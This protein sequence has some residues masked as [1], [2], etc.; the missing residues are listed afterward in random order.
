MVESATIRS[1]DNSRWPGQLS[2][3]WTSPPNDPLWTDQLSAWSS[4]ATGIFS[5]IVALIALFAWRTARATLHATRDAAVAARESNEQAKIDSIEQT[6]PYVYA[7]VVPGLHG[8]GMWDLRIANVGKSAA[9]DLTLGYDEWPEVPDDVGRALRTFFE[10]PRTLPPGC[11]IRAIWRLTSG[12]G[13]FSDGSTEAG[14]GTGGHLRVSYT[15]ADPSQPIYADTF[16]V[17]IDN[18]GM[19]PVSESGPE[20]TGLKDPE[21]KFYLLGQVIARRLGEL[22]R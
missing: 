18:A 4:V 11:S 3:W 19:W 22:N 16:D 1:V 6:R 5:A 2:A 20:P 12:T 8:V 17:M 10:T 15:S 13:T 7:E 14:L 21:R 9:R